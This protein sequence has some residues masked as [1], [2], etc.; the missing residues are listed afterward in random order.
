MAELFVI[1]DTHFGHA[2]IL[3]FK[4]DDGTPLRTFS[5]LTEMHVE[6]IDRWN[7]V[8]TP[9]DKVYHLGDVAMSHEG[10]A[11]LNMLNG[12]KRLVRGNHDLFK[13]REY[14][15]YFKEIYGVRQLDGYWMTHVPMHDCSVQQL[16]CKG[17]IH[18]HLHANP[19]PSPKHLCVSVEQIDYTPLPFEEARRILQDGQA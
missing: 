17:N 1:A 13:T 6:M 15:A 8:V 12:K 2:N 18:G 14:L 10:L 19:T 4:R 11:L 9:R 7:R 16:R 3:N 5:C